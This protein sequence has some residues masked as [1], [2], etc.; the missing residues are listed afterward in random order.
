MKLLVQNII[1]TLRELKKHAAQ[2]SISAIGIA[3]SV[4]CLTFSLNWFWSETNRDYFRPEYEN[5]YLLRSCYTA[6]STQTQKKYNT[7]ISYY[8]QPQLDSLLREA[9]VPY[10]FY[11]PQWVTRKLTTPDKPDASIYISYIDADS[12]FFRVAG[13][14]MLAGNVR[15]A[16]LKPD[17]AVITAKVARELFGCTPAE[18]IGRSFT[19]RGVLTSVF[20]SEH[21]YTVEAV[22]EDNKDPDA[23]NIGYDV[24]FPS[25]ISD[26]DWQAGSNNFHVL[27]RTDRPEKITELLRRIQ[28][29]EL[30]AGT[31]YDL[32]PLRTKHNLSGGE[33]LFSACFYPIAFCCISFILLLSAL[34][35]L[36]ATYTSIFLSRSREYALHRSLGATRWQNAAWILTETTPVLLIG[37]FLATLGLEWCDRLDS[38]PGIRS[39]SYTTLAQVCVSAVLLYLIGMAYPVWKMQTVYRASFGQGGGRQG[40]SHTWLL[41]VQYFACAL[42]LFVSIGMQRQL[43]G[44]IHQDLGYDRENILRLHTGRKNLTNKPEPFDYA[45]LFELL[46]AEFRKESKSGITDAIAMQSDIFN[47]HSRRRVRL[48]TTEEKNNAPSGISDKTSPGNLMERMK[49]PIAQNQL[50][51]AALIEVPYRAIDFFHIRV[52]GASTPVW[53]ERT[54]QENKV[55]VIVNQPAAKILKIGNKGEHR[56]QAPAYYSKLYGVRDAVLFE[57]NDHISDKQL[58]IRGVAPLRLTDFHE[59]EEP[60]MLAGIPEGRHVC[61]FLEYDAVYVKHAPGRRAEAEEAMRR[62]LRKFNVPDD[63]ILIKPL[64]QYIADS[65]KEEAYYSRL[66]NALTVFSLI[67]TLSGVA[68]MLLYSL[69]LR[70]RSLAIHRLM[71]A[72]FRIIFR[73]NARTYLLLTAAGCTVAFFPGYILMKKWMEHFHYGSVPGIGFMLLIFAGMAILSLLIVYFQVRKAMNE[74]PVE[75]LRPES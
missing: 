8:Y 39:H 36:T 31:H 35:N 49:L 29:H 64:D 44:M 66:L 15:Q 40:S 63:D 30:D 54:E 43:S 73:Q 41:A 12:S 5:L 57:D 68:S 33:S 34:V 55:Q 13:V 45:S 20:F 42:L 59:P 46:P 53:S 69:R 56:E 1:Q 27:I 7:K 6:D 70:R 74:K 4:V 22:I 17:K 3:I 37:L 24:I 28:P 19:S 23:T 62:V 47:N 18:A 50:R 75:V 26:D 51:I 21:S 58:D 11:R 9:G 10:A 14:N 38:V 65:Y 52:E 48:Y 67:V 72:D 2:A 16:L 25:D 61:S 32:T 60:L 71:G